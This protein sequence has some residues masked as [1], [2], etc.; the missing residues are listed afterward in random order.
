MADAP[1]AGRIIMNGKDD[2]VRV[3]TG[4]TSEKTE[5][6]I[7]TTNDVPIRTAR[8]RISFGERGKSNA[9]SCK[10]N[11]TTN[12]KPISGSNTG[13]LATFRKIAWSPRTR[14]IPATANRFSQNVPTGFLLF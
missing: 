2:I 14:N 3:K 13:R 4:A 1:H 9:L 6:E 11:P 5:A 8:S 7:K 12:S 10:T